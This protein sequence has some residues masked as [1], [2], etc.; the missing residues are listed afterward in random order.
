MTGSFAASPFGSAPLSYA[1]FSLTKK[2][3]ERREAARSGAGEPTNDAGEADKW[4]LMTALSSARPLLGLS[5]R[6]IAVLTALISVLPGRALK[7]DEEQIVF[8]SNTELSRRTQGMADATLRRHIA[9]LVQAGLIARR[10]SP[11]GKRYARRGEGGAIETAFGFDLGPLAL[12]AA[13]IFALEEAVKIDEAKARRLRDEISVHIRDI[14]KILDAA[15]EAGRAGDW[16]GFAMRLLPLA[17]RLARTASLEALGQRKEALSRLRA[18]CEAAWF[19]GLNDADLDDDAADESKNMSANAHHNERHIQNSNTESHFDRRFEKKLKQA[20]AHE[21]GRAA[22]ERKGA[23]SKPDDAAG[24]ES[25]QLPPLSQVKGACPVIGDYVREGLA[26]YGDLKTAA[27]L[28]RPMLGISPDAWTKAKDAFGPERAAIVIAC[29]LERADAIRS[30]GG[31]LRAL[32]AKAEEG[33][34]SVMPMLEALG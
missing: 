10:D 18:E 8:P 7:A 33:K 15:S 6:T 24:G 13:E 29:M 2:L 5:D 16:H 30:A 22:P 28:V 32:T 21:A 27:E 4:R 20:A 23:A 11:N 25:S 3:S 1:A 17:R 19:E 34:F 9:A 31:Y 14:A 12:R 26:T